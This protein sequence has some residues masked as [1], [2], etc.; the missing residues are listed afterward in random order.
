MML[1]IILFVLAA[2]VIVAGT[3]LLAGI[4][5][6][7]VASIGAFTVETSTPVAILLLVAVVI[8]VTILLRVVRGILRIPRAGGNWR[9]HNRRTVGER[10]VTR[11]LVALAAGEQG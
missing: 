6:H 1:K 8:A 2:T 3:W 11:V 9:R 5:G 10:A 4:P 7:V